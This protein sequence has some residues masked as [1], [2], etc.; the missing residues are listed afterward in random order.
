MSSKEILDSWI[1]QELGILNVEKV[2]DR[3]YIQSL[4]NIVLT[5]IAVVFAYLSLIKE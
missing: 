4:L 1:A 2:E 5:I 3:D